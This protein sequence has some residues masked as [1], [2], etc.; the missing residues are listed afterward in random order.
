M[1]AEK[2]IRSVSFAGAGNVAHHLAPAFS[3]AGCTI[4]HVISRTSGSAAI[5]ATAVNA[6]AATDISVFDDSTDLL[7]I[8]IPDNSIPEF[9]DAL[10]KTGRFQGIVVHTS[11]S[12]PLDVLSKRFEKC[13]V[14]YPLQSF[15][16]YSSPPVD[17]VPFC[18]EASGQETS[19]LLKEL[20]S[21]ISKDVRDINSDQRAVI[22]L[23]AVFASN[24]TNHMYALAADLLKASG[25]APD[26]LYPLIRETALRLCGQ[27]PALLQTGPAVRG[28]QSTIQRHLEMLAKSP[29]I[30]EMYKTLSNSI[31]KLK[32][33]QS[34]I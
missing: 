3:R 1:M 14:L 22:H 11:G 25:V 24:F 33:Q 34:K 18:I 2:V 30:Q 4:R 26:I 20:A 7:V 10:Q 19:G 9:A 13:G 21:R 32:Q 29:E 17:E 27:E 28:D 16:R 23:S 12:Q 6:Q 15:S 8:A 5:L 31:A